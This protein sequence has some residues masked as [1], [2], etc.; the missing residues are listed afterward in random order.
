MKPCTR[1]G[2]VKP[3]TDFHRD[4]TKADGRHT[5]CAECRRLSNGES[6]RRN[7]EAAR[8]QARRW[9]RRNPEAKA[10]ANRRW[11]ERNPEYMKRWREGQR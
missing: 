3:L 2:E 11:R 4:R 7:P 10:E 5:A 6:R 8:E 1:C 9:R